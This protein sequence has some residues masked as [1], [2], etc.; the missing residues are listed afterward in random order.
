MLG[1][2]AITSLS[3]HTRKAL[4]TNGGVGVGQRATV[5]PT[6]SFAT[7]VHA[8]DRGSV[9]L[10]WNKSC[11]VGMD[12]TISED[13][14]VYDAVQKFSA[15]D[16]GALVTTDTE[17][18]MSGV[19]SERDYIKKISLLEKVSKETLIKDIYTQG[20]NVVTT[21]LEDSI[22]EC[23]EKM[24]AR[25]IRHIPI[26]DASDAKKCVGMLS[27]KDLIKTLVEDKEQTIKDLSKLALGN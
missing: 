24:M 5:T 7:A 25:E 22:D 26:V 27:I 4:V 16:V 12:F 21:T 13:A 20:A 1:R 15:Y 23:M 18:Q 8:E 9:E 14:T 10:A 6:A 3:R 2:N 17:G 19:I 11:Y